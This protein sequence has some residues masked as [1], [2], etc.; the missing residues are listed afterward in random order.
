MNV[1]HDSENGRLKAKSFYHEEDQEHEEE[2][3][4]HPLILLLRAPLFVVLTFDFFAARKDFSLG[5]NLA[6]GG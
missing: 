4:Q 5:V 2:N 1:H 6:L 3:S